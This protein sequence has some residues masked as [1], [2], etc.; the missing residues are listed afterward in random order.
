MPY[1][2]PQERKRKGAGMGSMMDGP[3]PGQLEP[4][5][6]MGDGYS[7]EGPMAQHEDEAPTSDL[8]MEMMGG[9]EFKPGEEIMFKVVS[10]D[11]DNKTFKVIYAP[12]KSMDHDTG[13]SEHPAVSGVPEGY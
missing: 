3:G 13:E 10:V 8:P 9:K 6:P 1:L 12:E 2:T 4:S 11:P 5:R 7:E